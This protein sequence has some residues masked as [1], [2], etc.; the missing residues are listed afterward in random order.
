MR[1]QSIVKH[2]SSVPLPPLRTSPQVTQ[3]PSGA[4]Q[5]AVKKQLGLPAASSRLCRRD[6]AR[7]F[8]TVL[9]LQRSSPSSSS[10]SSPPSSLSPSDLQGSGD[11]SCPH[12]DVVGGQ[13]FTLALTNS[14]RDGVHMGIDSRLGPGSGDDAVLGLTYRQLKSLNAEYRDRLRC[15]Y[16]MP[17]FSAWNAHPWAQ[18]EGVDKEEKEEMTKGE[19][20]VEGLQRGG[21]VGGGL[22]VDQRGDL[23]DHDDC[24][25]GPPVAKASNDRFTL[26]DALE[27]SS[28]ASGARARAYVQAGPRSLR[29]VQGAA[30]EGVAH[31]EN[32][33][34][35]SMGTHF[36]GKRKRLSDK[37]LC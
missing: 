3:A 21:D 19:G 30:Q 37:K 32:E 4:L 27:D 20:V 31:D 34:T 9:A 35:A 13:S 25:P 28:T 14:S 8:H 18:D 17:F 16:S 22:K 33:E 7:L 15:Y 11:T 24:S 5:G 12:P 6:M 2:P 29:N 36:A 23:G 1:N 10:S 26:M